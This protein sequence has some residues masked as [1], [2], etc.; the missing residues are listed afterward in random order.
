MKYFIGFAY[1][2]VLIYFLARLQ[3]QYNIF[4]TF[5]AKAFKNRQSNEHYLK[6]LSG[7]NAVK[8]KEIKKTQSKLHESRINIKVII[9]DDEAFWIK[10][11]VFYTANMSGD[12]VDKET[13]RA[14][15][16]MT[17]N[18]VQLDKMMFIIDRL[19][20]GTF[21]DSGGTGY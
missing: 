12:I 19:R 13:T 8:P 1:A 5:S 17:M 10:D 4:Y 18:K 14:V 21:N 3:K 16:T 9:V 6:V 11:N 20:E 15:D 7:F 2:F